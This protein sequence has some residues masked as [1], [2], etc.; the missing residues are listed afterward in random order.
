MNAGTMSQ[1]HEHSL[2]A[3]ELQVVERV[4][5]GDRNKEIAWLLGISEQTVKNHMRNVFG[6]LGVQD[7]V[8]VAV[9][10]VSSRREVHDATN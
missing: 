7:R 6:K 8:T 2:S 3:R 10:W 5:A 4:A 1:T 9:W